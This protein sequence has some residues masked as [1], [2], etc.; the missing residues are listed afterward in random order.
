[1]ATF[2]IPGTT[3]HEFQV[4]RLWEQPAADL[5]QFNGLLPVTYSTP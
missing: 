5:L 2:S 3:H 1:M 4:I